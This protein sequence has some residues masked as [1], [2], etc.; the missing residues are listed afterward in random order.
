MNETKKEIF[1]LYS[2]KKT[3]LEMVKDRGFDLGDEEHILSDN[4]TVD[5]FEK[6]LKAMSKNG[7]INRVHLSAK[8]VSYDENQQPK[9]AMLVVYG[10]KTLST[11]SKVSIDVVRNFVNLFSKYKYSCAILIID[12]PLSPPATL[13]LTQQTNMFWQIFRDEDLK[14]NPSKHIY[15]PQHRLLPQEKVSEKLK[16]LKTTTSGL[17]ILKSTDRIVKYYGWKEGSV[18]EILRNDD[19]VPLLGYKSLTYRYI[20]LQQ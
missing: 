11:N 19:S 6:Y 10:E 20:A 7:T 5:I 9:D 15:T 3:Q 8:Y 13:T 4:F 16:E 1:D 2:V 12:L 17:P 14:V 18:V